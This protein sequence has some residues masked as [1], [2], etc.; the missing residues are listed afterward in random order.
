MILV[1]N[2]QILNTF[3]KHLIFNKETVKK[4]E[5]WEITK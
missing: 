3:V 5:I 1:Y 4:L 2:A